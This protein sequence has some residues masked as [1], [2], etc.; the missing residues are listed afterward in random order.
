MGVVWLSIRLVVAI[1]MSDSIDAGTLLGSATAGLISRLICHPIDTC[2]A[3]IQCAMRSNSAGT[4]G[5]PVAS[6]LPMGLTNV[7]GVIRRIMQNEGFAGL[8]RGIGATMVG[9]MPATCL[10]LSSYEVRHCQCYYNATRRTCASIVQ[11]FSQLI[12][13]SL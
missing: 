8:Y 9:G 6:A 2:K 12:I 1:V 10:Y 3:Q 11:G 13:S 7:S 5:V 4:G